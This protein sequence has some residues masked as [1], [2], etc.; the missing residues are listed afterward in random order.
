MGSSDEMKTALDKLVA[1][2]DEMKV[3]LGRLAPLAP[4]AEELAKIPGKVV[5]HSHV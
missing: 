1:K 5:T 2:I 3:S 4:V